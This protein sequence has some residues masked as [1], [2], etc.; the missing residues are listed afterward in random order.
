MMAT[1]EGERCMPS[2][3]GAASLLGHWRA[4]LA[5]PLLRAGGRAELRRL[6][7]GDRLAD[8]LG[9]PTAERRDLGQRSHRPWQPTA[10]QRATRSQAPR[11]AG[12][13]GRH[14]IRRCARPCCRAAAAQLL[15]RG[16]GVV[17]LGGP[18]EAADLAAQIIES[19]EPGLRPA[20]QVL[21]TETEIASAA[22]LRLADACNDTGI[23][24]LVAA[25]ETPSYVLLG[26]RPLLDHDPLMR[27]LPASALV[28]V[29]PQVV[30]ERMRQDGVMAETLGKI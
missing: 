23:A 3:R 14:G 15:R 13:Q 19:L 29:P 10:P 25:C 9:T 27:L 16:C 21:C 5:H 24:N 12:L 7:G 2:H 4:G 22:I 8:P 20:A 18:G 1:R 17:L 30:L 28:D 26:S 11:P 6:G